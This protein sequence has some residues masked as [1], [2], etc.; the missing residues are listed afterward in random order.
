MQFVI[1]RFIDLTDEPAIDGTVIN[2]I[3]AA[4][5]LHGQAMKHILVKNQILVYS[6]FYDDVKSVS[7]IVSP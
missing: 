3:V 1:K 7:E 6:V 5:L 2:D 4:I